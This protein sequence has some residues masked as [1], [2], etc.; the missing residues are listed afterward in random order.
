MLIT[1][2]IIKKK[3]NMNKYNFCNHIHKIYNSISY[4][5]NDIDK[6]IYTNLDINGEI[7]SNNDV[8]YPFLN[9]LVSLFDDHKTVIVELDIEDDKEG[10]YI[11]N[12]EYRDKIC[13]VAFYQ[14]LNSIYPYQETHYISYDNILFSD[15]DIFSLTLENQ[16]VN[17]PHDYILKSFFY[18]D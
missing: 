3:D 18:I 10:A 17:L 1:P 11:I 14:E 9:V 2:N 7:Y 15:Q 6:N 8:K 12:L 16:K 5:Y 4:N 13:K